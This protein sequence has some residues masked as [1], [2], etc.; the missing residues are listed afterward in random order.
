MKSPALRAIQS[1][2]RIGRKQRENVIL[3][4]MKNRMT[5]DE[6]K[7]ALMACRDKLP[8]HLPLYFDVITAIASIER[9]MKL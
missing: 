8:S 6:A 1:G 9:E 7:R 3:R 2:Q 4:E 5:L